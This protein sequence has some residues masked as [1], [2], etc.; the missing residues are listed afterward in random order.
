[1]TN[2]LIDNANNDKKFAMLINLNPELYLDFYN[3]TRQQTDLCNNRIQIVYWTETFNHKDER[4]PNDVDFVQYD[5]LTFVDNTIMA[6]GKLI[7]TVYNNRTRINS[8]DIFNHNLLPNTILDYDLA[9]ITTDVLG[10]PINI[11]AYLK[12]GKNKTP[13]IF[14][15]NKKFLAAINNDKTKMV[16]YL[17]PKKYQ[18][19]NCLTN[20]VVIDKDKQNKQTIKEINKNIKKSNDGA[21]NVSIY[22]KYNDQRV[23]E[24]RVNGNEFT[25]QQ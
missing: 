2:H 14:K 6:N 9:S 18:G 11:N 19:I 16:F 8:P 13:T 4:V 20:A 15:K 21:Y 25:I 24:I 22:Y 10:R 12:K 7:A 5:E 17:I 1:M 23:I 3:K